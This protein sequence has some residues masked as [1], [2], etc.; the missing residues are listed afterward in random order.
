MEPLAYPLQG[1]L[2]RSPAHYQPSHRTPQSMGST[3]K[4]EEEEST[5]TKEVLKEGHF[6]LGTIK[7]LGTCFSPA[8]QSQIQPLKDV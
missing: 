8:F 7:G 1:S 5:E 6:P 4:Q 2:E 3:H